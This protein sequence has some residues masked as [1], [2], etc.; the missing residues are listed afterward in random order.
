M[1]VVVGKVPL[2]ELAANFVVTI[3]PISAFLA[4][5][6]APFIAKVYRPTQKELSTRPSSAGSISLWYP[7]NT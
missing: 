3:P 4:S 5:H 1:L 6:Q 7:K 2:T